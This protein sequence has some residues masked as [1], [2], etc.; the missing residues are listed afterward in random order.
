M[1]RITQSIEMIVEQ[2]NQAIKNPAAERTFQKL[3]DR[4]KINE[5]LHH[6]YLD[7]ARFALQFNLIDHEE[8]DSLL[9]YFGPNFQTFN[10]HPCE[11][12][13]AIKKT[14]FEIYNTLMKVEKYRLAIALEM[15]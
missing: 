14:I 2:K 11:V 10:G 6:A 13:I 3:S 7:T 4:L 15:G 9:K 5:Q 1:N 8:Y 12:R